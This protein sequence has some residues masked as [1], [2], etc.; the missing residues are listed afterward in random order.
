[1][2]QTLIKKVNSLAS[3][4]YDLANHTAR[5]TAS[6]SSVTLLQDLSEL[7]NYLSENSIQFL[8][9]AEYNIVINIIEVDSSSAFF[10]S[11]DKNGNIISINETALA[12]SGYDQEE[13]IGKHF[14]DIFIP[15]EDKEIIYRAFLDVLSGEDNYWR[16]DNNI[17]L[18]DGS[19]QMMKWS[20]ALV[21]DKDSQLSFVHA[22]GTPI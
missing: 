20:N 15:N 13:L 16:Y 12:L 14:F 9:D 7:V 6:P 17:L 21:K 5:K 1:M 3:Y 11:L 8:V 2:V 4:N 22:F 10:V 18:K 19:K